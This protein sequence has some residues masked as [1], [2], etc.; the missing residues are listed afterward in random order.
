ML[1]CSPHTFVYQEG[2]YAVNERFQASH[3]HLKICVRT[4]TPHVACMY[5]QPSR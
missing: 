1:G 2:F 4:V 3:A 5:I